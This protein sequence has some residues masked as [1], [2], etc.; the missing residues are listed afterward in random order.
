MSDDYEPLSADALLSQG[1]CCGNG[2]CNCPYIPRHT[3]GST[4]T[5]IN[6]NITRDRH[7]VGY[8]TTNK[9]TD[10]LQTIAGQRIL[11]N[12]ERFSRELPE[13]LDKIGAQMERIAD[14]LER[15]QG[16]NEGRILPS[17]HGEPDAIRSV[18]VA[19][20]QKI[21]DEADVVTQ[22]GTVIKNRHGALDNDDFTE[23]KVVE[24]P[25]QEE[26]HIPV[27]FGA[28]AEDD[29]GVPL[30]TGAMNKQHVPTETK[31]E[32]SEEEEEI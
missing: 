13:K 20:L 5:M 28:E 30:E 12:M 29:S 1:V 14:G 7:L 25:E 22:E 21:I 9:M 23:E 27:V 6:T 31:E 32:E 15:M 19:D 10:F 17:E 4:Q 26:E 18:D 11:A 16:V 2:C 8:S 3:T 24:T